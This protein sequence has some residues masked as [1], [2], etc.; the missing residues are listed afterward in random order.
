M[1]APLLQL[2]EWPTNSLLSHLIR[3]MRICTVLVGATAAGATVFGTADP[4]KCHIDAQGRTVVHYSQVRTFSAR[5]GA[6]RC[7]T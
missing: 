1:T 6:P 2:Q 4:P 3:S 7:L 5:T